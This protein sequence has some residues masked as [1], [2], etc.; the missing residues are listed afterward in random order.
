MNMTVKTTSFKSANSVILKYLLKRWDHL[1]SLPGKRSD[2]PTLTQISVNQKKTYDYYT[3]RE[4]K[5]GFCQDNWDEL[6]SYR[7]YVTEVR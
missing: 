5:F 6:L 7:E 1:P 2:Y 3:A 4:A